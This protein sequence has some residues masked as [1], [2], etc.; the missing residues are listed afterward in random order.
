MMEGSVGV[1]RFSFSVLVSGQQLTRIKTF[2]VRIRRHVEGIAL[3]FGKQKGKCNQS[4][5]P[6]WTM[7]FKN[8][9]KKTMLFKNGKKSPGALLPVLDFS[10]R[11]FFSCPF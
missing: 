5:Y 9:K 6:P 11:D 4:D 10:S 7:L 3:L 8:G 1:K 2:R